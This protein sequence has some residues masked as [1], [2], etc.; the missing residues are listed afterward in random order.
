MAVRTRRR[1]LEPGI[2]ARSWDEADRANP[3]FRSV[4]GAFLFSLFLGGHGLTFPGSKPECLK[5]IYI[6]DIY[7]YISLAR[8]R[9]I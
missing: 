1:E 7:I 4:G 3:W 6:L 9:D 2:I 5:T 8:A